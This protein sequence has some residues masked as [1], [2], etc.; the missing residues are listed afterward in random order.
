MGEELEVMQ[1]RGF[2][3]NTLYAHTKR[4]NSKSQLKVTGRTAV[5]TSC[6]DCYINKLIAERAVRRQKRH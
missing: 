2:H 1:R 5:L 3:Q 4:P 6:V